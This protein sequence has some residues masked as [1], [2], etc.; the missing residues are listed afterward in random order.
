MYEV[1]L[2]IEGYRSSGKAEIYKNDLRIEGS[3]SE[4]IDIEVTV[5]EAIKK[6]AE[7]DQ[8]DSTPEEAGF[9]ESTFESGTDGRISKG[10]PLISVNKEQSS[11]GSQSLFVSGRT[12]YRNGAAI[13]LSSDTYKPNEGYHFRAKVMQN[14]GETVTMKMTMQYNKTARSMTR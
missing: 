9:F 1:A 7:A 12:D 3:Y 4:A 13:M 11:E 6:L 2:N 10:G 5:E 14:S 8:A